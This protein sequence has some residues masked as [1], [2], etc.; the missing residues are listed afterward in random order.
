MRESL[1]WSRACRVH[2][3]KN[4]GEVFL[5]R[6]HRDIQISREMIGWWLDRPSGAAAAEGRRKGVWRGRC[7]RLRGLRGRVEMLA[8]EAP[9]AVNSPRQAVADAIHARGYQKNASI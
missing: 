7:N 1:E 3:Y 4:R 6:L 2:F 8:V 9:K 5:Q